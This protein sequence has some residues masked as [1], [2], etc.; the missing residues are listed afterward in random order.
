MTEP[1]DATDHLAET[2]A[3]YDTVAPSYEE[4]LRT[5][6]AESPMDRALLGVFAE[7]VLAADGGRSATSAADRAG[8]PAT[9]TPWASRCSAST[10]PPAWSRW[11]AGATRTC[12]SRSAL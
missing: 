9:C 5:A 12:A 4:L 3:A 2:R 1:G 8:S 7:Q 6:L 10:S 11:P